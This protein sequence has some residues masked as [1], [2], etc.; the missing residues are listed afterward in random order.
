MEPKIVRTACALL[1]LSALGWLGCDAASPVAPAGTVLAVTASPSQI[2]AN[3]TSNI[4]VTALK[5]NGTPVNPGTIV[6]L[7]TT[8]GT[9]DPTAEVDRDG[10]ATATLEGDGRIGTATVT[11]TAGTDAQA[12]VDVEIGKAAANIS[13]QASPAQVSD[14]GGDIQLL[15]VVRDDTG[16]PLAN[17]AVNFQAEVGTLTSRGAVK[18]TDADGQVQDKLV[19]EAQDL[20]AITSNSFTATA[21]VGTSGGGTKEDTVEIRINRCRPEVSFTVTAVGNNRVE[22]VNDTT[23][24]EPIDW[25][26]DFN[27]DGVVDSTLRSPA[28]FEYASPGQKTVRL[29]ATNSCGED[30][31]ARTVNVVSG[32]V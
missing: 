25:L 8:L 17:A 24:Q 19:V 32:N 5:P 22:F 9:I 21:V 6:R 13:L 7:S 18:R 3:G 2:S 10:L 28:P 4:R 11:A 12:T 15:A 16:E 20:D 27:D 30:E 31:D 14:G 29:H 23:G 26:W 1:V